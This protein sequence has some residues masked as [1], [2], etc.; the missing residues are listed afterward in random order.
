VL[1]G[2]SVWLSVGGGLTRFSG[3]PDVSVGGVSG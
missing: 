2:W 3:A 1:S